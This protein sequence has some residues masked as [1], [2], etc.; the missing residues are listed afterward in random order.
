SM[1]PVAVSRADSVA[2]RAMSR[3][4]SAAL[5]AAFCKLPIV[6][7]PPPVV[8]V[9]VSVP[10][11]P[12]VG[13]FAMIVLL[14]SETWGSATGA[15]RHPPR[16]PWAGVAP[17]QGARSNWDAKRYPRCALVPRCVARN[18]SADKAGEAAR[19]E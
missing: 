9:R 4:L 8:P 10:R 3:A 13:L 12:L 17:A 2:L 6:P 11:L 15:P 16:G 7:V 18:R 1:T 19:V 14:R 5:P